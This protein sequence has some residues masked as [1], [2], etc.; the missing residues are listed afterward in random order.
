MSSLAIE[1]ATANNVR[2]GRGALPV[3]SARLPDRYA[4]T[5][6]HQLQAGQAGGFN[7]SEGFATV[8]TRVTLLAPIT[9]GVAPPIEGL[10]PVLL[11]EAI[12]AVNK[13]HT[14]RVLFLT[15]V[16]APY[17]TVGVTLL[18]EDANGDR[19]VLQLYNFVRAREDPAEVF[20]PGTRLAMLEPYLR[21]PRDDPANPVC[22]RCDNPQAV[23]VFPTGASWCRAQRGDFSPDR[24]PPDAAAVYTFCEQGNQQFAAGRFEDAA[25][26]YTTA[27]LASKRAPQP[28]PWS[29]VPLDPF[30][31]HAMAMSD[32]MVQRIQNA[33][34]ATPTLLARVLAN[35]A[36]CHMQQGGWGAALEDASAALALDPEHRKAA[37]R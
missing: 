13:I 15:S 10:T 4:L 3:M 6:G 14:G 16:D 31:A 25:R 32:I 5:K 9:H 35:R 1:M 26:L 21:F 18:V 29:P 28:A 20:P 23:R 7:K 37:Y 30:L 33:P 12:T 17:R 11:S 8:V 24:T 34:L 22:M 19:M 36:A 2:L 27:L